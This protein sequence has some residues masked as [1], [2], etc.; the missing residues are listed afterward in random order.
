MC[1]ASS[2]KGEKIV[3]VCH[4]HA[5]FTHSKFQLPL[6]GGA[7]ES[8]LFSCR[9]I[10]ATSAQPNRDGV[11]HIF[12]KVKS[13]HRLDRACAND[14]ANQ[15]PTVPS[16]ALPVLRLRESADQ[17]LLGYRGSRPVLRERPRG[18]TV[19]KPG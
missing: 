7:A 10:D 12:I 5:L 14:R 4:D 13:Q 18:S 16:F 1:C 11:I 19:G 9:C 17:W 8:C 3:V 15:A 2:M 6:I